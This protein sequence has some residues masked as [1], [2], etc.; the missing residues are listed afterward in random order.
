MARTHRRRKSKLSLKASFCSCLAIFFLVGCN[1]KTDQESKFPDVTYNSNSISLYGNTQGTTY[2]ILCND[3]VDVSREE[4]DQLLHEF[5]LALSTYIPN[6]IISKFNNSRAG[7]F[8]YIDSNGYFND[9]VQ[10]SRSVY[11]N[12]NGAFDPSVFP[13][14]EI[15]GFFKNFK[16][17]PDSLQ[18]KNTLRHIGFKPDYHYAFFPNSIDTL[19]SKI[20]KRT[21]QFKIVFNAI[22]QGQAVD[23]ICK[24]LDEKGAQNY[25]VEIGGE[26]KVKGVNAQ[27]NVW[28]IGIDKPIDNSTVENREL[29]HVI[30]L[31]NK[32]V[33]TSG[34]YRQFYEKD[35]VKYSHTINP[36]S[37]YPV[38][39]SLLSTTVVASSCALADGYATAFMVMGTEQTK[40]FIENNKRLGL[41]LFLIYNNVDGEME[42]FSTEGFKNILK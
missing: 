3:K 7:K 39:H 28:T 23:V 22:A 19:P 18:I 15:W 24:Y 13:L 21:S 10:L 26:V 33:A 2:A 41:D 34:N 42:T 36:K 31:E 1:Q 20:T 8:E 17:I 5:D 38:T 12:T 25:Y 27:G 37:G 4:I 9:C 35:G 40:A 30:A 11:E 32:S 16:S 29:I 6:S 14:L